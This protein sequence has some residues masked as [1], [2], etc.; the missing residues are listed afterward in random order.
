MILSGSVSVTSRTTTEAVWSMHISVLSSRQYAVPQDPS[1]T[2]FTCTFANDFLQLMLETPSMCTD[3]PP[4]CARYLRFAANGEIH[5]KS[6]IYDPKMGKKINLIIG[7]RGIIGAFAYYSQ[8]QMR[9]GQFRI[10]IYLLYPVASV[11]RAVCVC[12]L[13]GCMPNSLLSTIKYTAQQICH[14]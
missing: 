2:H 6:T 12:G 4:A 5:S 13:F 14:E 8:T 1:Q 10:C 7:G 11:E 3:I 9:C